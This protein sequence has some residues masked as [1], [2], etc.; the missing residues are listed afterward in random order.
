MF[1][2]NQDLFLERHFYDATR[3]T[4]PYIPVDPDWF[5]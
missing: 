5:T 3:P 4:L 2:L 1:T